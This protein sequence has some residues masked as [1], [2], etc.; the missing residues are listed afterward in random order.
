MLRPTAIQVT[1]QKDYFL[2]IIFN[3]GEK[4][5]FDVRPYIRGEWYGELR[6]PDYFRQVKTD[7][8]TVVWPHGQDICPDELYDLSTEI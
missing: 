6:E 1:P 4:R 3:N 8:F 2:D 7:G 5:R